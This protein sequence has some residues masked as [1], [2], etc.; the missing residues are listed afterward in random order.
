MVRRVQ[1]P[2]PDEYN[3]PLTWQAQ[4]WR[5]GLVLLVSATLWWS[6]APLQWNEARS[7]FWLDVSLGVLALGLSFFRRRWPL[8][9]AVVT[10]VF[11]AFSVTATGSSVLAAVSLATRRVQDVCLPT[12]LCP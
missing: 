7:L 8:P 9:V 4:V 2:S 12:P 10:N 3:P 11:G 6:T 1:R 5:T